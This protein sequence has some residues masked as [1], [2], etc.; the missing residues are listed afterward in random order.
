MP[1]KRIKQDQLNEW[2]LAKGRG[3]DVGG[4]EAER[5]VAPLVILCLTNYKLRRASS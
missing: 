5:D 1:D 2:G 4:Q 3:T